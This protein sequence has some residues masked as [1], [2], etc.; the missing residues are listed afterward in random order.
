[1]SARLASNSTVKR[2]VTLYCLTNNH[3]RKY[4][5]RVLPIAEHRREHGIPQCPNKWKTRDYNS[6]TLIGRRQYAALAIIET[7]NPKQF[8]ALTD[9]RTMFQLT[10]LRVKDRLHFAAPLIAASAAHA[11]I[12]RDQLADW[13]N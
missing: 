11:N 1:M 2:P 10:V 4:F 9:T 5:I 6:C 13:S 12:V 8:L 3:W 7:G